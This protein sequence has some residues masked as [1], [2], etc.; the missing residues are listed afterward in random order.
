TTAAPLDDSLPDLSGI[1][2][3]LV[4]CRLKEVDERN[5]LIFN[6]EIIKLDRWSDD[7]KQGLEREIKEL[8]K[9]IRE[10]RRLA[11][12]A[13]SLS[14][15]LQEQRD[16][17]ALEGTRSKKRKELFDAQDKIDLQRDELIARIECQLHK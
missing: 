17:K 16:L 3:K 9:A 13:A 2:E 8:D 7:L 10:K 6:E 5:K 14:D 12:L 1:R 4:A 15:K 11:A